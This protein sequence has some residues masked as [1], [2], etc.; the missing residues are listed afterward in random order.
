[1]AS[2]STPSPAAQSQ[3]ATSSDPRR[4][5]EGDWMPVFAGLPLAQQA[6]DYCV[7][8]WQRSVLLLDVMRQRGNDHFEHVAQRTPNVLNFKFELVMS[9]TEL[10]RPV[11]YGLLRRP[12]SRSTHES[13]PSLF[14][15]RAPATDPA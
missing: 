5:P 9:G 2:I 8:A 11:N 13:V 6:F 15:I 7:D 3:P 1:M 4:V 12:T 10:K 14:S